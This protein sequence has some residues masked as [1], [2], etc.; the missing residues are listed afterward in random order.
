[1]FPFLQNLFGGGAAA[2]PGVVGAPSAAALANVQPG[3]WSNLDAARN[4]AQA[5]PSINPDPEIMFDPAIGKVV[6]GS[7]APGMPKPGTPPM[8]TPNPMRQPYGGPDM[9]PMARGTPEAAPQPEQPAP[10][11]L[12]G[13]VNQFSGIGSGTPSPSAPNQFTPIGS[14]QGNPLMDY[15]RYRT[16]GQF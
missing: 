1:M 12:A 2:M 3:L 4:A 15:I 11:P 9:P 13:M 10:S 5:A 8:P 7:L 14:G 16:G 6:A